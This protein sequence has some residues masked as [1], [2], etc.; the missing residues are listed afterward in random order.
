MVFIVFCIAT[1]VIIYSLFYMLNDPHKIKFI[2]YL[3]L[4]TFSMI[5]LIISK[6]Y[7]ILFLGWESIGLCSYLLINFWST[8]PNANKCA[9][10]AIIINRIGD[11]FLTISLCL[12]YIKFKTFE[13][14]TITRIS[15]FFVENAVEWNQ[16]TLLTFFLVIAAMAK[17]AQLGLHTWLPD[18]MEGPTPVS[19]LI[20]AATM[21]TA[22]IILILKSTLLFE[23][24][25]ITLNFILVIGSF[26][27]IFAAS[28][29]I[30]QQ[31]VKKIIAFSTCSQLGYMFISCAI[32]QYELAFFHLYNH[33]VFKALLFLASGL[34]IHAFMDEQDNRKYGGCYLLLQWTSV[35]FLIGSMSLIAIPFLTGFYSKDLIIEFLATHYTILS[36]FSYWNA[37][38]TAIITGIYSYLIFLKVFIQKPKFLKNITKNITENTYVALIPILILTFFSVTL[39]Y[40]SKD[41]FNGLGTTFW[42]NEFSSILSS[43]ISVLPE[44]NYQIYKLLP[45]FFS[46]FV[47][48]FY[49]FI[50]KYEFFICNKLYYLYVF[51]ST[52]WFFDKVYNLFII[53]VFKFIKNTWIYALDKGF[54]PLFG[55]AGVVKILT[56]FPFYN[57]LQKSHIGNTSYYLLFVFVLFII[58]FFC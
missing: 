25:P 55:P 56:N 32:S 14:E 53:Q 9:L 44:F 15:F 46:I 7:F 8:R 3:F 19:A 22:G 42:Q 27:T 30:V 4:F 6:N 39:G 45:F 17:S 35:C 29:A 11:L 52:K 33:A 31:D 5:I 38:V 49:Y 48:L 21:V 51:F 36:T 18:A 58:I 1:A 41:F 13:I 40:L 50:T 57:I 24:C 37:I 54:L 23:H 2:A 28:T 47:F 12:L 20:H 43:Q 26:T 10:K 16:I 34:I